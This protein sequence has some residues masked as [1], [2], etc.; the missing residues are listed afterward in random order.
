MHCNILLDY[1]YTK[2]KPTEVKSSFAKGIWLIYIYQL[3]VMFQIDEKIVL[4]IVFYGVLRP[5]RY[6]SVHEYNKS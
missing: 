4:H 5:G 6:I 3:N 2:S 1:K